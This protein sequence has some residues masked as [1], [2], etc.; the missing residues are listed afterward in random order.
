VRLAILSVVLFLSGISALIFETL[1]LRLSGLAFGNSIWAA[2][3]ILSSF[4]AGL[5]LGTAIAASA[6]FRSRPLKLYAALEIAV[7]VLGCTIVFALPVLGELLRPLFQTLWSHQTILLALRVLISFVILLIPTTAM[8]LTLPLILEDRELAGADFGK[9]IGLLYGFN[10]I[11]AVAGAL[12]GELF[13]VKAFGLFGTSLTAGMLNVVAAI[14]ALFLAKSDGTLAASPTDEK[15]RRLRLEI[16]YQLPWRLLIVSFGTGFVLLALEVVWFRFL[17]LYVASSA[18]AFSVMLAVVLAGIGLGGIASGTLA[19]KVRASALPV[20][21][22]IAAILTLLCY[23]FFPIPKLAEGEKNF[24]LESWTQIARVSFALM[25]PIAFLSGILFPAIATRVQESVG[26][27]MNSVGITTLFNT[28]GAAIGP[29]LAGFLLLPRVGFQTS[30]I[31][32]AIVYAILGLV[33]VILP[34]YAFAR[35]PRNKQRDAT[36]AAGLALGSLLIVFIVAIVFFPRHRDE[37]HFANARKLYESEEQHLVKKI[38]GETGTWQLL[39]RNLFG[40]PYYYRLVTDG[41]SMSATN[42]VNQRYMRLFAYLAVTLNPQPQNALLIAFGCGVTADALT[43]DVDLKHVDVVDISKEAFALADDYRNAGYSNALRDPRVSAIVQDGRFFLQ[44]SPNR[45]DIITGEPPPPKVLGSVNLYTEQFFQL[46]S[47]RLNDGGIATFWLPVYQ[48]NVGEAKSILHAFHDA[49]PNTLIWSSSDEEWIMM[50]IKGAPRKIDN[51]QL[52]RLWDYANTRSDLARIG[53]E[54]PEQVAALFVMDGHEIDRIASDANPL[55]DF[56]PK[57]LGD[58]TAE[59]PVIHEF[60]SNYMQAA[61]AAR[62]FRSS[63]LIEEMLPDE[64]LNAQLD[65][66]FVIREMRYHARLTEINWLE[67]LDIHLRGSRLREPVL[68]T[69]GTNLF[70]VELA[71]KVA[72]DLHPPPADVLPDLIAS[73]LS[74]RSYPNAIRLLEDKRARGAANRD[75]F[76]LLAY[77]YCLNR[78]V[79]KAESIANLAQDRQRPFAKWLW[80]KLQT[81]YGFRPPD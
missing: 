66:F 59:D 51:R 34:G 44:A 61:D 27:R 56:Y 36:A 38:E 54:V 31:V 49:F 60:T 35:V 12:F 19:K 29:L 76:F 4:M 5:A 33:L 10:T 45:Y 30:L 25:F 74:Q 69:L 40:L 23:I 70:R 71:E 43:Q 15:P 16:D 46:M 17:R 21:L 68:E 42:P 11:G 52:R 48:L 47:D 2:A 57:R 75:D 63:R 81:E 20:L 18:T 32:C 3:L 62:R 55:T 64:I 67:E 41:F 14:I 37:M 26:S 39:R 80:G 6:K 58:V 77:L 50:G 79:E 13:L 1:W 53:V 7:A 22:I 8:G 24:Y 73:S 28:A 9:A 78:E 65:P 72:D